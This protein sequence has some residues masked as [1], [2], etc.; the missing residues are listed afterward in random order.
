MLDEVEGELEKPTLRKG[1][2]AS[3]ICDSRLDSTPG[4]S[5]VAVHMLLRLVRLYSLADQ[6]ELTEL[7]TMLLAR[8]KS[9]LSAAW[10]HSEVLLVIRAIVGTIREGDPM[11]W[12][13]LEAI[14]SRLELLVVEPRFMSFLNTTTNA[15]LFSKVG[16]MTMMKLANERK[17]VG[18]ALERRY[19]PF[20]DDKKGLH[21]RYNTVFA[22]EKAKS[23]TLKCSRCGNTTAEPVERKRLWEAEDGPSNLKR[24][25]EDSDMSD[26]SDASDAD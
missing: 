21:C 4:R 9:L 24:P 14:R 20:S 2:W 25:R 18:P 23:K 11:T 6:Y 26:S 16:H 19:C 8:F 13:M 1:V 15:E 22:A 17:Q 12:V 3:T 10:N 7:N 5:R